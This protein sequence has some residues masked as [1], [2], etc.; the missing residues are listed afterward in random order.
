MVKLTFNGKPIT[1]SSQFR[2]E[3]EKAAKGAIDRHV[4][5]AAPP[6]VRV[7]KTSKGYTAEG[8]EADIER[9]VKRL[10]R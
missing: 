1:S 4:R 5:S 3:F 8:R 9:M 2:R 10:G 6:G 7:R